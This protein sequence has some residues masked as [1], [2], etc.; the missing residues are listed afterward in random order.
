M[1]QIIIGDALSH[2]NGL[3]VHGCNAQG[4]MGSGIALTIRNTYP[5]A[6]NE[7]VTTY[8]Q[9]GGLVL[10]QIIP[11]EVEPDKWI[12]NAITQEFFGNDGKRYVSYEAVA[13][14][15]EAVRDYAR[16]VAQVRGFLPDI[17]YPLIGAGL[18]RGNWH[19]IDKIIDET[20]GGEF[21]QYVY[22][23]QKDLVNWGL[24]N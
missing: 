8:N 19:I 9:Q 11:V 22:G 4:V 14:A 15:F 17:V 1:K 13:L 20:L 23:F 2:V 21:N 24:I 16:Q 7:Y 3:I 12:I 18:A 10:G 6:Y 5:T